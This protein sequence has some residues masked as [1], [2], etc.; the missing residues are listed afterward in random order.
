[1]NEESNKLTAYSSAADVLECV[2]NA[3]YERT[4]S[5]LIYDDVENRYVS[6]DDAY[7]VVEHLRDIDA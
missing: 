4:D 5:E 1:M 6:F 2:I 7:K 3:M